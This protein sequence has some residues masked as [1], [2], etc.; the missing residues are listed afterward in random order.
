MPDPQTKFIVTREQIL[1]V[2][3]GWTINDVAVQR[4]GRID[5]Q[6]QTERF[7]ADA[8]ALFATA[9]PPGIPTVEE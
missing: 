6:A 1:A 4:N 8:A 5:A 2:F 3:S 9:D 7:L